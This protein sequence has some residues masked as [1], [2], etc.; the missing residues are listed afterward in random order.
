MGV[1]RPAGAR[2]PN[3]PLGRPNDRSTDKTTARSSVF[4]DFA[5]LPKHEALNG[6]LRCS[7]ATM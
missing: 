4:A 6:E 1:N 7:K 3:R 2:A 5:A